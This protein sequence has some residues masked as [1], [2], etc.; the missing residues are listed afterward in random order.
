MN[1]LRNERDFFLLMNMNYNILYE[2]NQLS[3]TKLTTA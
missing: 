2:K 3:L 1:E